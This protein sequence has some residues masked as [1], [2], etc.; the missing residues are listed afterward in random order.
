MTQADLIDA[1]DE[2]VVN[3]LVA[4]R[5]REGVK[6]PEFGDLCDVLRTCADAWADSTTIPKLATAMLV[7]LMHQTVVQG[8]NYSGDA[9]QSIHRAESIVYELVQRCVSNAPRDALDEGQQL[10]LFTWRHWYRP[11][12]LSGA[13]HTMGSGHRCPR[14]MILRP[15]EWCKR[16]DP[17]SWRSL[18][19]CMH[20]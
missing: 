19:A 15:R 8:M 10:P 4:L 2:A 11:F 9:L 13:S 1:L 5:M 17:F 3:F 6:E 7:D 12:C 18:T 14:R 20:G 16:G